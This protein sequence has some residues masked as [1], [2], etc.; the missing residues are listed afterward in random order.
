[1]WGST[2]SASCTL[3]DHHRGGHDRPE[4]RYL[5]GI[6]RGRE[7]WC[8]GFSEPDAGA[9]LAWLRP[10]RSGRRR[11]RGDGL[12]IWTSHAEAA[13]FCELLVRTG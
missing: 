13:D 3:A 1:M 2:S 8:Q 12:E 7:V 6:L 11:L 4:E 10:G 9:D 5:P